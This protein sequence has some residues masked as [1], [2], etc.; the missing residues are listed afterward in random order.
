MAAVFNHKLTHTSLLKPGVVPPTIGEFLFNTLNTQSFDVGSSISKTAREISVM[1]FIRSGSE[2]ISSVFNV[3]LWTELEN[4]RKDVK[5]KRCHR[6]P[7]N[8]ISSD[9]E[10]F[11]FSYSPNHPK[12]YLRAD[13]D[14]GQNMLLELFVVGYAE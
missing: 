8:A 5:F 11:V 10:T 14:T 7:Q 9:S 4:D 3:W 2:K 1:V 12:L 13:V 6:Y